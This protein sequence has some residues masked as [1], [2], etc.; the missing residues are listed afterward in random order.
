MSDH[1]NQKNN[2][3]SP[4]SDPRNDQNESQKNATP[5]N[6]NHPNGKRAQDGKL[7]SPAQATNASGT[8]PKTPAADSARNQ[9]AQ[10]KPAQEKNTGESCSTDTANKAKK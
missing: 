9:P 8:Q 7:E 6:E 4:K 3:M 10:A 2:S 5:S 1:N